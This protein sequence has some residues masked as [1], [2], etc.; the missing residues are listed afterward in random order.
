MSGAGGN[1]RGEV[2]ANKGSTGSCEGKK[3]RIGLEKKNSSQGGGRR[4]NYGNGTTLKRYRCIDCGGEVQ[5]KT[6]KE[7]KNT[8]ITG[9]GCTPEFTLGEQV[10]QTGGGGSSEKGDIS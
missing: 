9:I 6:E 1:A 8:V 4:Q 2:Q 10:R 7:D 5:L 3:K